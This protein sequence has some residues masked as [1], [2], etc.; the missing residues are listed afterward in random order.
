MI[1]M[2]I[3]G[4]TISII[5]FFIWISILGYDITKILLKLDVEELVSR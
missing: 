2:V 4:H 1:C 3:Q 5:F